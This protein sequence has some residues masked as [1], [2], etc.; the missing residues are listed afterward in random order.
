MRG[1]TYAETVLYRFPGGN[2]FGTTA[3]GGLMKDGCCGT[4]FELARSGSTFAAR[5]LHRFNGYDG[6]KPEAG[7]I[8]GSARSPIRDENVLAVPTGMV[9]SSG[10]R[11]AAAPIA[12]ASYEISR[13]RSTAQQF[14]GLALDGSKIL[15]TTSTGRSA[16]LWTVFETHSVCTK[17]DRASPS[18]CSTIS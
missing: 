2:L 5:T 15:G 1:M 11:R 12:S 10:Y 16:N 9:P 7:L 18:A 17:P 8:A 3:S 6:E 4:V 13:Y 14:G